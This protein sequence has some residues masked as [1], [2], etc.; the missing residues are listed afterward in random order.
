M[1]DLGIRSH[2]MLR[3]CDTSTIL[4]LVRG[5]TMVPE[6]ALAF[7]WSEA[8]RL[9]A[10][11]VRGDFVECGVWKG[12]CSFGMALAQRNLL[13]DARRPVW[14]F[15]S[16]EGLPPATPRDG[17]A[18]LAYQQNTDAPEYLDNCRAEYPEVNARALE[19]G[20]STTE[21]K[22]VPGWFDQTLPFHVQALEERRISLLRIDADWFEPVLFVLETLGPLVSE[23]G[24]IIVD[25]YYVWDGCARAVHAYL[26]RNDL[27][28]R[29]KSLP[30]YASAWMRVQRG[31]VTANL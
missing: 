2:P 24:V 13:K 22:I 5:D 4:E 14:M 1:N 9:A 23:N 15:D 31:R 30:S 19:L 27:S 3:P 10:S 17:C 20:L 25:D 18:A 6:D 11:E 26:A 28:W 7:T 21:C 29:I 8:V 12:G 16:F